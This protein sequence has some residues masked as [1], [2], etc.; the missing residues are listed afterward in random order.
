M[1]GRQKVK[2]VFL[3]F[4][5]VLNSW[6]ESFMNKRE[7][8]TRVGKFWDEVSIRAVRLGRYMP[9]KWANAWYW[10]CNFWFSNYADFCPIACSNF[11]SLLEDVPEL[12][13]V[14][15]SS[16]RSHGLDICKRILKRNG[17]DVSRIIGVTPNY[18]TSAE[19]DWRQGYR[20]RGNE[21]QAWMYL[22]RK[23]YR[24]TNMVILDD[25]SD[26]VHLEDYLVKTSMDEGLMLR[27]KNQALEVLKRPYKLGHRAEGWGE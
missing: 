21:I 7:R 26:M 16:W 19:G 27:H 4:D 23:E 8:E 1:K 6:Q 11:I 18:G 10:E 13:I 17:I 12:K 20:A 24:V 9:K 14:I 5:G 2:V 25:N 15:S 22:F 3:D